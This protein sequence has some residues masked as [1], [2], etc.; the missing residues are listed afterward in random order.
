MQ[1]SLS[2]SSR[3]LRDLVK[4]SRQQSL[5]NSEG[6]GDNMDHGRKDPYS[7]S[8]GE[9]LT[10]ISPNLL[11]RQNINMNTSIAVAKQGSYGAKKNGSSVPPGKVAATHDLNMSSSLMDHKDAN[12]KGSN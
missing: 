5:K 7:D 4:Q 12:V 9:S 3:G 1:S 11:T 2:K 8:M 10:K 6:G